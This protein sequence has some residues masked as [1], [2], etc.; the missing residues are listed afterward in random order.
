MIKINLP[1]FCH[2]NSDVRNLVTTF[3]KKFIN[4]VY[5]APINL[6]W[7][8][9]R[10]NNLRK[11][12]LDSFK[13]EVE[14]FNSLDI[15]VWLV[16]SRYDKISTVDTFANTLLSVLNNDKGNGVIL[17]NMSLNEHVTTCYPKIRRELSVLFN[18]H[19]ELSA[20]HTNLELRSEEAFYNWATEH[21]DSACIHPDHILTVEKWLHNI[22]SPNKLLALLNE[23]CM[24][25]CPNRIEHYAAIEK[26]IDSGAGILQWH[27]G[28]YSNNYNN[29]TEVQV[30]TLCDANVN[31]FKV[32]GREQTLQT[33]EHIL[34]Q[35]LG[36]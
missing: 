6:A 16:A 28:A 7:T 35:V 15:P 19:N 20:E 11:H 5:G 25:H 3:P 2:K 36:E 17:S 4:A 32:C 23:G 27:C 13:E 29:L 24:Y 21:F 14:F 30:D 9:G 10:S 31:L 1:L 8:A 33:L 26:D 12:T 22:K 18:Y 34:S